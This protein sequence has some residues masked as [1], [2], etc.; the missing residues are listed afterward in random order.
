MRMGT[1]T[2]KFLFICYEILRLCWIFTFR[3]EFDIDILPPSWYMATPLLILP[4]T[5]VFFM[6]QTQPAGGKRVYIQI[7]AYSKFLSIAGFF[8]FMHAAL[9]PAFEQAEFT[10]YYS[11]KRMGILLIFLVIDA[12]LAVAFLLSK[13]EKNTKDSAGACAIAEGNANSSENASVAIVA[14]TEKNREESR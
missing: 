12:I 6:Y 11:L 13:G 2:K 7:Y 10:G 14:T 3:P 5:L 4:L 8:S 1:I 9:V